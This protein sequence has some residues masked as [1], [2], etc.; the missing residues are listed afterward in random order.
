MHTNHMAHFR[1]GG[2][3]HHIKQIQGKALIYNVSGI[4]WETNYQKEGSLGEKCNF[5]QKMCL[6]VTKFQKK[7]IFF[8][9]FG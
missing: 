5:T 1:G 3:D 2:E 6:S 9:K 7:I 4:Q 8:H